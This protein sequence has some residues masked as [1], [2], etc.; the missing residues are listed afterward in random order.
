MLRQFII[1]RMVSLKCEDTIAEA[2]NR[3]SKH[4]RGEKILSPDMRPAAYRAM[5]LEGESGFD[6][7]LKVCHAVR[8]Y[9]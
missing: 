9:F 6:A 1:T 3:F 7:L 5:A 4:A 8:F 2:K